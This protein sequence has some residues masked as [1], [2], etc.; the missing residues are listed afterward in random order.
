MFAF[1]FLSHNF[2]PQ[3]YQSLS[4]THFLSSLPGI[5]NLLPNQSLILTL[6][7]QIGEEEEEEMVYIEWLYVNPTVLNLTFSTS[8]AFG[9]KENEPSKDPD[10]DES[11]KWLRH[12]PASAFLINI[13]DAPVRLNGLLLMSFFGK[14][15]DVTRRIQKQY[16]NNLKGQMFK[17]V[18]A[19]DV[20]GSPINLFSGM[21]S[22]FYDFFHEPAKGILVSPEKFG[23]GVTRSLNVSSFS[24]KFM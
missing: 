19:S 23:E 6:P 10:Q 17:L 1:C 14:K 21:K 8:E 16:M 22:G 15:S 13:S 3:Y 18:G 4:L 20:L 12:T 24:L 7:K 11:L 5:L 9:K 2:F